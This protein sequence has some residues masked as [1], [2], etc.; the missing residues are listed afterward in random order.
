MIKKK[1]NLVLDEIVSIENV[2][3]IDTYDFSI[4]ETHCFFANGVLVHNT[5]GLEEKSER[6]ILLNW[7]YFH[8]RNEAK[9]NEYTVIIAKNKRGRTG[10]HI[11]HY[12]PEHY[13]FN[14]VVKEEV[15]PYK[16]I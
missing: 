1:K 8:T 10:K 7:D 16:D 4:P 15:L 5:G 3:K 14:E 12:T 9:K 2:G 11:L 13:R 6:V